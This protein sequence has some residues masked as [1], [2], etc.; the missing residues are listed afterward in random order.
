MRRISVALAV[1]AV[2]AAAGVVAVLWAAEQALYPEWYVHSTPEE[3]LVDASDRA[4]WWGTGLHDPRIDYGIP[5][6]DVEF[7]GPG[8]ST[9]RGWWVPGRPL[10][11]IGVVTV[12]GAGGD[13]RDFLR[14][15]PLLR[16]AGYPVLMFDCREHGTSD[17][18]AR[19][20]SFGVR[21]HEDVSAAVRH[22]KEVRG[23]ERVV[24]I[25]TS[26]G[27][28][29]ALLAAASDP[30]IDGVVAI[31]AF[32]DIPAM[33]ESGGRTYG[34]TGPLGRAFLRAGGHAVVW[35]L[36]ASALPTPL[37]AVQRIAPRPL[38]LA[39][40]TD[41]ALIDVAHTRAL[42][43]AAPGAELWIL[44]GAT[45]SALVDRDPAEWSRRVLGFIARNVGRPLV[46][47]EALSDAG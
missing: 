4:E 23:L 28:A 39:H 46:E 36:G 44:D 21:E 16:G 35:R 14:H 30:A 34:M 24:V 45:H 8:G 13:R 42:A 1:L 11:R 27:A 19:G 43:A 15:L 25:G 9:L 37:E 29:S 6:E 7:A 31:N 20:V 26:Q 38:L 18:A 2:L 33:V 10:A 3:G 12:H 32:T 47:S 17:G 40:G 22:A 41:D 5:F